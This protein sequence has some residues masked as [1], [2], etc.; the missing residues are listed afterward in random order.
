MR[1]IAWDRISH[2][3]SI[4]RTGVKERGAYLTFTQRDSSRDDSRAQAVSHAQ[5]PQTVVQ[6][7]LTVKAV[8]TVA[9]T[10]RCRMGVDTTARESDRDFG[11]A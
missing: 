8:H 2:A 4:V 6:A 10:M 9:M 1:P 11:G 7:V 3:L 5:A